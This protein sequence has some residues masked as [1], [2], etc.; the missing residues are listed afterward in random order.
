MN[1]KGISNYTIQ[2]CEIC[3]TPLWES[4]ILEALKK[5]AKQLSKAFRAELPHGFGAIETAADYRW[6]DWD[7]A[8][9]R[10]IQHYREAGKWPDDEQTTVKVKRRVTVTP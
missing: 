4:L 7:E 9:K 1:Y 3:L 10:L 8:A 6:V 2:V 5:S